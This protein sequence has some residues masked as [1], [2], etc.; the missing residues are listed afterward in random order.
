LVKCPFCGLERGFE[1][2]KSWKSRFYDV[3]MLRCPRCGGRF[4]HY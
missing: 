2:L 3:R 4:D 1:S